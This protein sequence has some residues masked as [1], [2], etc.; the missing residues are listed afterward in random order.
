MPLISKG[1][2]DNGQ[3]QTFRVLRSDLR[4]LY[5]PSGPKCTIYNNAFSVTTVVVTGLYFLRRVYIKYCSILP[6][7]LHLLVLLLLN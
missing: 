3:R 6:P 1:Y 5:E 4:N 7:F 2:W